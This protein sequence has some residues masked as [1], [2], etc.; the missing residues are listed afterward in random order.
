MVKKLFVTHRAILQL[1]LEKIPEFERTA[2]LSFGR[3]FIGQEASKATSSSPCNSPSSHAVHF[4]SNVFIK[5]L[6]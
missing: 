5:I 4:S 1:G 3:C 6:Q 2:F